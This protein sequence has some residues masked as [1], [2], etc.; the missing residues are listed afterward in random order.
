[1]KE[2]QNVIFLLSV[3]DLR[4]WAR[5]VARVV[6]GSWWLAYYNLHGLTMTGLCVLL[7]SKS[8]MFAVLK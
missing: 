7:P 4:T 2:L 1:M 5:T 3:Q 8:P 6:V